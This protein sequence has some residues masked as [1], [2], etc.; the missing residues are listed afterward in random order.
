MYSS[1]TDKATLEAIPRLQLRLA[2]FVHLL[3]IGADE[4]FVRF[5]RATKAKLVFAR[6]LHRFTNPMQH[7][8]CRLLSDANILRQFV[9]A[10]S[11]LAVRQKPHGGKPL[12]QGDRGI[13]KDGS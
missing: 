13:L 1:L 6:V 8:P 2:V 9:T 4:R 7:E 5:H 10:D 11:V 3:R 12:L